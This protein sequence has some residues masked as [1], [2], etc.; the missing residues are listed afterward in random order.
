MWDQLSTGETEGVSQPVLNWLSEFR[1][2]QRDEDGKVK[3]ANDHLMDATR[4]AVMSWPAVPCRSSLGQYRTGGHQMLTEWRHWTRLMDAMKTTQTE[5]PQLPK[6]GA[7]ARI[8]QVDL[9]S[10]KAE[11]EALKTQAEY[12]RRV[13]SM[14]IP[15]V[16]KQT[17][18][19]IL[20]D[21]KGET[22]HVGSR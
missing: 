18:T 10:I 21:A 9:S 7:E 15:L 20:Q 3:K 17:V 14:L 19:R 8:R 11:V 4:Y 6:P 5:H 16:P 12:M 13:A 1:L 22:R 2:Y